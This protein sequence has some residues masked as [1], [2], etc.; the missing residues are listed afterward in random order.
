MPTFHSVFENLT[1]KCDP[2]HTFTL[3]AQF[4]ENLT[5]YCSL[6]NYRVLSLIC[7]LSVELKIL[8][9]QNDLH[10][11]LLYHLGNAQSGQALIYI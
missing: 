11:N 3:Y 6:L 5:H 7:H 9:L 1:E 8:V 4:T 10:G 2:L